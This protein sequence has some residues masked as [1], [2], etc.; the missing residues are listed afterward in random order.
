M[1]NFAKD[2]CIEF[3]HNTSLPGT[4]KLIGMLWASGYTMGATTFSTMT[5]SIVIFSIM[6][7]STVILSTVIFSI[8]TLSI[9][10]NK[11]RHSP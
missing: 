10:T 6:T 4:L 3:L 1:S 7:L 5:L 8:M 9:T 11:T 2:F